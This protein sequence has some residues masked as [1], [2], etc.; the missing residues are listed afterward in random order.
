MPEA[1][2]I[3][4]LIEKLKVD[5]GHKIKAYLIR[6]KIENSKEQNNNSKTKRKILIKFCL[7]QQEKMNEKNLFFTKLSK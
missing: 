4:E 7:K 3:L 1:I 2:K 5:T 6:S